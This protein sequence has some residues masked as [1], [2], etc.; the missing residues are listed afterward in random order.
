VFDRF[1]KFPG[2]VPS[3]FFLTYLQNHHLDLDL[4]DKHLGPHAD[5]TTHAE[6]MDRWHEE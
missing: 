5:L 3:T 6:H 4:Y 1:G 2:T